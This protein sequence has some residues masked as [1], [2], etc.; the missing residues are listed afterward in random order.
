MMV[1]VGYLM[2]KYEVEWNL[3]HK[4]KD[5]DLCNVNYHLIAKNDRVLSV[6]SDDKTVG[7]VINRQRHMVTLLKLIN[8][9]EVKTTV[10]VPTGSTMTPITEIFPRE[11]TWLNNM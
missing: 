1:T 11:E 4:I 3:P 7:V 2:D 8:E 6:L 9:K 10:W 5:M